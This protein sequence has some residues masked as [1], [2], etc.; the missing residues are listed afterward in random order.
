[1]PH[2]SSCD[3]DAAIT[4]T[5]NKSKVFSSIINTPKKT[6]FAFFFSPSCP[7]CH[8]LKA[9]FDKY[10]KICKEK[11]NVVLIIINLQTSM[12]LFDEYDVSSFPQVFIYNKGK[13]IG[14]IRGSDEEALRNEFEKVGL[15][16]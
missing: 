9:E 16:L 14:H 11:D 12:E 1:M 7:H 6:I 15:I 13:K 8:T 5:T 3:S 10:R 2:H 4:I